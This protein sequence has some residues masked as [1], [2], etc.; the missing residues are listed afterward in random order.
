ML[1]ALLL[2]IWPAAPLAESSPAALL[3]TLFG[4]LNVLVA[5]LLFR[6]WLGTRGGLLGAALLAF[7]RYDLTFAHVS[8]VAN[9]APCFIM[10]VLYFLERGLARKRVLDFALA[11]IALGVGLDFDPSLCF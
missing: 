1:A 10:L 9:S 6:R 2:R 4:T 8:P 7:L 11:G 3:P 5:W